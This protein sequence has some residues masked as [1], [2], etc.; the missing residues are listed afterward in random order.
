MNHFHQVLVSNELGGAGLLALHLASYLRAECQRSQV[1]I[2]GTGPA[3]SKAIDLGLDHQVYDAVGAF[4]SSKIRAITCNWQVGRRLRRHSPGIVHI[5]SPFHYRAMRLAA[6]ISGLRR[7]VHV[8]LEDSQEGLRW[9][10]KKPP[11]LIITCA[12][13]L[14]EYVRDTLPNR[15]RHRQWIVPLPNPVDT[16]VFYPGDKIV[17]K[18][19]VGAPPQTPMLL[20]L[21]NLAPHKGQETA[22]KALA[23]LKQHKDDVVLWLAGNERGGEKS[24]TT[25][26]QVLAKELGVEERVKFLGYR[27]DAPELLRAAD[28]FLLPST[29]EGLPLSIL[30]AQATKVPVLASPTAGIP[31]V[32]MDGKTGILLPADDT[33]GYADCIHQLLSN[34][35]FYDHLAEEAYTVIIKQHSW[36]TYSSH[37]FRLYQELLVRT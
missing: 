6:Q 18:Q 29:H 14:V 33:Q 24:Y 11:D 32:I 34:L 30:E 25:Y 37:I 19:H 3:Q 10:F 5:H 17:A 23:A 4:S 35:N 27:N 15:N 26:L 20:M 1:W 28:I 2:P 36:K 31:E 21:A 8:Q 22:I 13:F 7:V 9:A 12:R 16:D